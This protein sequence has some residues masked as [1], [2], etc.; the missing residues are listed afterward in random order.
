MSKYAK[1]WKE[2]P[3]IREDVKTAL[4]FFGF[5]VSLFIYFTIII[6]G[7]AKLFSMDKKAEKAQKEFI[8]KQDSIINYQTQNQR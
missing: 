6:Y 8:Q 2:N 1:I 7:S 3:K 4:R 5:G